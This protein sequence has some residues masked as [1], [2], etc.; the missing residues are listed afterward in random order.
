[1]R[2]SLA[3]KCEA[4]KQKRQRNAMLGEHRHPVTIIQE[5]EVPMRQGGKR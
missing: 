1:M 3:R 2:A 5:T 4:A